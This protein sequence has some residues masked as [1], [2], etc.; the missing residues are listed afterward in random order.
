MQAKGTK[1]KIAYK[2]FSHIYIFNI[3]NMVLK[4]NNGKRYK[5]IIDRG[6]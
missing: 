6:G 1:L 5:N 2:S 4:V 3:Y